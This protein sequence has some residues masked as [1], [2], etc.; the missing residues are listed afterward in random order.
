MQ[1]YSNDGAT[2]HSVKE[3]LQDG[4]LSDVRDQLPDR[5]SPKTR[6]ALHLDSGLLEMSIVKGIETKILEDYSID[7]VISEQQEIQVRQLVKRVIPGWQDKPDSFFALKRF[8]GGLTNIL[9][10]VKAQEPNECLVPSKRGVLCRIYGKGSENILDREFENT[11]IMA[12]GCFSPQLFEHGL[13]PPLWAKYG[14][15]VVYGFIE[16][17][18]NNTRDNRR[19]CRK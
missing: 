6:N 16:V 7:L 19:R 1:N 18:A 15:G 12:V 17:H 3:N 5:L 11:C 13:A 10:Y 9:Y 4:Y 8:N 14:N 2:G